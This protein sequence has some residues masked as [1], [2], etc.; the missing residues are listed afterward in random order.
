[1]QFS[2]YI[3]DDLQDSFKTLAEAKTYYKTL[4]SGKGKRW[5]LRRSLVKETTVMEDGR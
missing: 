1:M 2:V 3:G 4:P 5:G